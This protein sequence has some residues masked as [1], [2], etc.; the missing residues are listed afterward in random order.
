MTKN[1]DLSIKYKSCGKYIDSNKIKYLNS[2]WCTFF[3]IPKLNYKANMM[4]Y[5]KKVYTKNM[6]AIKKM[7]FVNDMRNMSR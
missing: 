1:D 6:Y 2:Q 3:K 7:F 5:R 4:G